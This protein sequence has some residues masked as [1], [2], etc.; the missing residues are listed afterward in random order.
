MSSGDRV[1]DYELL[2]RLEAIEGTEVSS[3]F[4]RVYRSGRDPTKGYASNGRWS[5]ANELEVLYTAATREGALAEIGYRLS[6]EPIWPSRLIHEIAELSIQLDNICDLTDFGELENLGV[7]I[8]RYEAHDY[9]VTQSIAAAA[10]FL[11]FNGLLVPNAR[12]HST[13]LVLF[14][15]IIDSSSIDFISAEGVEWNAWRSKNPRLPSRD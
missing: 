1:H 2:D 14:T 4:F 10:R 8:R 3:R 7:D 6:L 12:N 5:K 9:D 11:E 13:N 15:E